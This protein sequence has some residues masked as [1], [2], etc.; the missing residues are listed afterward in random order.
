MAAVAEEVPTAE[1]E[2]RTTV[3]EAEPVED[4]TRLRLPAMEA[5]VPQPLM[6]RDPAAG[7]QRSPATVII[8]GPAAI[9]PAAVSG[10]EITHR[11]LL[12]APA[13]NGIRS[14]ARLG[15]VEHRVRSREPG[16]RRMREASKSLAETGE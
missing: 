3:V 6:L 12:L 1:A 4:L 5:H 16:L 10:M 15:A 9:L 2:A 14:A 8:L 7:T 13:D 11:R